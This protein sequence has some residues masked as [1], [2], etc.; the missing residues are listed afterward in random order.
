MPGA[1]REAY[2]PR[3]F[4]MLSMVAVKELG[5]WEAAGCFQRIAWRAERDGF[6][7]AT[8]AQIAEEIGVSERTAHRITKKLRDI[9]WVTADRENSWE[10]TLTWRIIIEDETPP[11]NDSMAVTAADDETAGQE[12]E[13]QPVSPDNDN[14][15]ASTPPDVA[16]SGMPPVSFS[17]PHPVAVSGPHAVAASSLETVETV[18]TKSRAAADASERPSEADKPLAVKIAEDWWA[19]YQEHHGQIMKSG[20]SNPFIALRDHIV[21]PAL[22]AGW[23]E[24]EIKLALAGPPGSTPDAVPSKGLFQ[25]R[26]AEVRQHRGQAPGATVH[27]IGNRHVTENPE[28]RQRMI[29]A[30]N[31]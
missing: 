28:E 9:G 31:G 3:H 13:G 4:I 14:L 1:P 26:L 27:H 5:S 10:A 22:E 11:Q 30:F 7:R 16:V 29:D 15:A 25:R 21:G 17:G 8:M 24:A 20:R 2:A 6:W 18:E 23:T 19:Y 12:P